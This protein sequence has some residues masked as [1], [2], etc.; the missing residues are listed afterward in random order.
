LQVRLMELEL[1]GQVARLPGG[2]YQRVVAG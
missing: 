2:L 1:D